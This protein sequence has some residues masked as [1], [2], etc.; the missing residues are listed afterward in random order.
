MALRPTGDGVA[1]FRDPSGGLDALAWRLGRTWLITSDGGPPPPGLAPP[2]LSL[3]WDAIA[4]WCADPGCAAIR[5]GLEGLHIAAP[6][7]SPSCRGAG[8]RTTTIW[9]PSRIVGAAD[10]DRRRSR[11]RDLAGPLT[12]AVGLAVE[13]LVAPHG[14]VVAE[15]SGGLDSAIVAAALQARGLGERAAGW[16]NYYGD[17]D[18]GD[19]RAYACATAQ[20]FGLELTAI[21]KPLEPL[22]EADFAAC[23]RGLRPGFAAVDPPRDRDTAERL[24]AA[25]ATA[26]LTGQGG[27]LAFFQSPTP[28]DRRRRAAL[29]RMAPARPPDPRRHRPA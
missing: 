16:L 8:A 2:R 5:P 14:R 17:R 19:E 25:G 21:G 18:E 3:D 23:A 9:R 12:E 11:G 26:L 13:G 27:D 10:V 24:R 15:L 4:A 29:R 1:I 7:V 28:A 20:R 6:A 22:G